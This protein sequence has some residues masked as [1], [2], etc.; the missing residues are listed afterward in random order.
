MRFD[1][2]VQASGISVSPVDRFVGF[3]VE[4]GVPQGWEPLDSA[5]GARVWACR[6]DPCIDMFCANAVLT[7]HRVEATLDPAEAFGMLSEQQLQSVPACREVRRELAAATEGP[8][9]VG[10]LAMEIAHELGTID[11]V[12]RSRI[13]TAEQETLIAQLTTTEL[14]DSPVDGSGVWL[15]ARSGPAPARYRGTVPRTEQGT[16]A[17]G[18]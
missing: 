17:D 9:L 1:E 10:L 16:V 11:S 12:S 2:F 8:G 13:I 6:N 3:V 7:M 15:T 5:L 18:K 4:V 14:H